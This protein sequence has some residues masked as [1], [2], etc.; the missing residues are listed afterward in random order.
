MRVHTDPHLTLHRAARACEDA[1]LA[2]GSASRLHLPAHHR[3]LIFGAI[4]QLDGAMDKLFEAS[5]LPFD[6]PAPKPK[7]LSLEVL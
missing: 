5:N 4:R 2:A 7:Q 6:A 1:R 3:G